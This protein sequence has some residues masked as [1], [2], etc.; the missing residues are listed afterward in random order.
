MIVRRL[1]AY[2]LYFGFALV[3]AHPADAAPLREAVDQLAAALA[4]GLSP[5]SRLLIAVTDFEDLQGTTS[6]L[7]RYIAERLTTRFAQSPRF[8]VIERRRLA[9]MLAELKFGMSDLVDPSKAKALGRMTGVEALVVGSLSDLGTTVEID[10]RLIE[11]ET[12][13][14]LVAATAAI[15]KDDTVKSMQRGHRISRSLPKWSVQ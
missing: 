6:E 11:L 13:G 10:A 15:S 5:G 1:T 7:S 8:R 12:G 2:L 9:E 4:K 3:V 14:L